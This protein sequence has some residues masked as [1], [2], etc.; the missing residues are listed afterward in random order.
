MDRMAGRLALT[1]ID[2]LEERQAGRQDR[3]KGH[4]KQTR[5]NIVMI[6]HIY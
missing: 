3:Q 1:Q 5:R 6:R 4:D 2:R